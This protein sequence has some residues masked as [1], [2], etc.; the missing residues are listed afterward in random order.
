MTAARDGAVDLLS[1]LRVLDLTEDRTQMCGRYLADLGAEVILVEPPGGAASRRI[2]PLIDG[3]SLYFE[4]HNA[5]KLGITL[6]LDDPAGRAELVRL[7]AGADAL[8]DSGAPGRVDHHG[9]AAELRRAN[10]KLTIARISEFGQRG[11]YR[12]YRGTNL[13]HMALNGGLAR[14]GVYGCDP[15]RPPGQLAYETAAIQ[16]A[17]SVLLGVEAAR[18]YGIGED[19]DLSVMEAAAKS[20]DPGHGMGGMARELATDAELAAA[21]PRPDAAHTFPIVRCAD[22]YVRFALL[23]PKQWQGFRAMIGEPERFQDPAFDS[24]QVRFARWSEVLPLVRDAFAARTRRDLADEAVGR[25]IPMAE[26][27]EPGEVLSAAHFAERET[28]ADLPLPGGRVGRAPDGFVLVDGRRAGLRTPAPRLGQHTE[29]V[30]RRADPARRD[31]DAA[32]AGADVAHPL[33]GVRV[34]DLGTIVMGA[35]L[36]RLLADMGADVVKVENQ[37]FPDGMRILSPGGV[38]TAS[39]AWG[40]RNKRGLGLNLRDS[41]GVAVCLDLARQADIVLSNF[42][43]GT[44]ARLGLTDE[45]L[46]AANPALVIGECSALGASGEWSARM[47]YG[48]LVRAAGGL[49]A[50][51]AYPGQDGGFGDA[52]TIYPDHAAARVQAVAVLAGLARARRT[53]RGVSISAAQVETILSQ[54]SAELVRESL[55]PGSAAPRGNPGEFDAP[56]GVFAAAGDEEWC[57]VEVDGDA[58]WRALA[59]LIGDPEL[60]DDPRYA[61]AAARLAHR[62]EAEELLA[63]WVAK[64]SPWEAMA[65]LQAAG[66]AAGGMRR[67]GDMVDDPH[68]QARDHYTELVQPQLSVPIP[69]ERAPASF[70]RIPDPP[71]R[72]APVA[73]Q[74]T[75]EVARDWLGM[76]DEQIDAALAEGI[77]ELPASLA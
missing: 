25:G 31:A 28:F 44:M 17:W 77:L 56:A 47:G 49:T 22:G 53:G 33:T 76:T 11:P 74:Q 29:A 39:V 27:M 52:V 21:R 10:P 32:E 7:A 68:L 69:A 75:R 45:A 8:L 62:Q 66:I 12:D 3:D 40:H 2:P 1:H 57:A 30:L 54:L 13:V 20:L 48:P 26:L 4:S 14:S 36:S 35:E 71:Q 42:K 58:Q 34:L 37:A 23:T 61:S 43:P 63:G 70:A 16:A 24:V 65:A 9:L 51:W 64:H 55:E 72:F 67:M 6:D 41:R 46:F 38:V 5:N 15:L 59:E 50:M 19:I 18:R 73:G 60:A